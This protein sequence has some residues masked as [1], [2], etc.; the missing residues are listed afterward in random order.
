AS[1]VAQRDSFWLRAD[2][3]HLRLG[4]DRMTLIP[5]VG[6]S[7]SRAEAEGLVAALN[8]HFG[9]QHR[10]VAVKAE[11]WCMQTASDSAFES[12]SPLESA[13]QPVDATLLRG[14]GARWNALLNEIQM[15]LHEHP[16]NAERELRGDP[17]INSVWLWGAGH[18]PATA[19][20][21]WHSVTADD[22]LAAGLAR[23]AGVRQ[24]ELPAGAQ[25]W[26]ERAP[27]EG[28][29]LVVLDM[30]RAVLALSDVETQG[31]RVAALEARW[32]TPLLEALRRGRIGMVTIHVPDSGQACETMRSDL[33]RFWRRPRPLGAWCP[34]PVAAVRSG[35]MTDR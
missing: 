35:T 32:F 34:P 8:R 18:I 28:R 10:F 30:L 20:G 27:D 33:R 21:P 11:Q 24:R 29:H 2:P 31:E 12:T 6:C 15:V 1:D 13:G 5:G 25:E 16:L 17:A 4:R 9:A 19:H 3:V 22:A 7:I 14:P 26:L 23:L